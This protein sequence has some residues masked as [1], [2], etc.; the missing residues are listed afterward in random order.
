MIIRQFVSEGLG[1]SSYLVAD[2]D[3]GVCAVIDP[4][5]DIEPYVD[6]AAELG[7]RITLAL[8][9]H[10]HADFVSGARELA[11]GAGATVTASAGATLQ[12]EHLAVRGGDVIRLGELRFSV[13]ETPGHTPEHVSFLLHRQGEAAPV[14]LFSG[15]ALI[16]G[17]AARTD[18][19]GPDHTVPLAKSLYRTLHVTLSSLPDELSVFPTHGPGS[20]CAASD[21]PERT[22]SMGIERKRNPL[23]LAG[24]EEE[25][26]R[27]ALT[28]LPSYPA[29]FSRMRA[30]NQAGPRVVNA[31]PALTP[32]A[33]NEVR[34]RLDHGALAIDAR[35]YDV[36]AHTHVPG[37]YSIPLR[38]VFASW[39]GWLVP[40]ERPLVIVSSTP[41]DHEEVVRQAYAIGYEDLAGYL[42]GG[43]DAW[44]AAGFDVISNGL[45][46]VAEVERRLRRP[47]RI[48]VLD[49]RQDAEWDVGHI[50]GSLHIELG[51]LETR[52]AEL[53][54]DAEIA[55]TC[56]HGERSST[57]A[58]VLERLGF[59][60]VFNVP[61]GT[62]AWD[63]AGFPVAHGEAR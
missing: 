51:A 30:L 18:L 58:S 17:G 47:G 49:V 19:I 20:F 59:R 39:L 29:Y 28:G 25:F 22:T 10:V 4:E 14:G 62:G 23:L 46:P 15:G 60:N 38:D 40:P 50:P 44:R 37:S 56:G 34:T 5:R 21:F 63:E 61:G 2:A 42:D 24:D 32:L 55:V 26:V 7:V 48:V 9:T 3:A 53:S 43:V 16:V 8:E 31:M 13:L 11:A 36:Y 12:F 27:V 33:P 57:G 52:A 6:A 45:M 1:N 54:R 41:S 35:P